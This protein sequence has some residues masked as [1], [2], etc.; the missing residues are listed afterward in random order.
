MHASFWSTILLISRFSNVFE[1]L[2]LKNGFGKCFGRVYVEKNVGECFEVFLLIHMFE[3]CFDYCCSVFVDKGFRKQMENGKR[4]E[5]FL[6]LF[7][8]CMNPSAF[9]NL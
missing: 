7:T 9:P 1:R 5:T 6:K 8:G 3:T 4:I 2:V